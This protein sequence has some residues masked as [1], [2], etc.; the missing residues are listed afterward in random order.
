[1]RKLFFAVLMSFV[2]S[3]TAFAD[4]VQPLLVDDTFQ[5]AYIPDGFDSNDKVQIAAEGKFPNTCYKVAGYKSSVDTV[6]KVITILPQ[7][8]KYDTLCLRMEVRYHHVIELGLMEAGIYTIK[9][10]TSGNVLGSLNVRQAKS[11]D[12]DD[13]LYAPV[14]SARVRWEDN[15]Y[16]LHVE[17]K[18]TNSCIVFKEMRVSLQNRVVVAQPITEFEKRDDC[19][20]GE[21]P[22]EY[23]QFIKT[24]PDPGRYLLHIRVLNGSAINQFVDIR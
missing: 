13:Y 9:D 14:L 2:S 19:V 11:S 23:E 4:E 7:A 16:S 17:G 15:D 8:Y 21:F 5:M 12:P 24:S 22:F 20:A 10:Q 3:Y 18:F 6:N 1:M